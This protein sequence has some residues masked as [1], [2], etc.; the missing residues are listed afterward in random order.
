MRERERE[1]EENRAVRVESRTRD[2]GG[3]RERG[4]ETMI[5]RSMAG[6]R[7]KDTARLRRVTPTD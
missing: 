1:R 6:L 3:M 5:A 7:A 2:T 4:G